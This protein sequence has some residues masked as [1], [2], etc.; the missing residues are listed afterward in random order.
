MDTAFYMCITFLNCN[1]QYVCQ[2][3]Q[4]AYVSKGMERNMKNVLSQKKTKTKT[5]KTPEMYFLPRC[6]KVLLFSQQIRA[7][8][9]L[10][11]MA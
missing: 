7:M 10:I 4:T 5:Q 8:K 9:Y 2:Q 1:S 11:Y 6:E 3:K